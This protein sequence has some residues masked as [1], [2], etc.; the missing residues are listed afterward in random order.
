MC[1]KCH[2][3]NKLRPTLRVEATRPRHHQVVDP[4]PT[5]AQRLEPQPSPFQTPR[6]QVRHPYL[7]LDPLRG[8]RHRRHLGN[9]PAIRLALDPDPHLRPGP[10]PLSATPAPASPA[11]SAARTTG[12]PP[13]PAASAS[14]TAGSK[15]RR[16][17]APDRA[18]SGQPRH[19]APPSPPAGFRPTAR[20]W[21]AGPAP[22]LGSP[23]L[24]AAIDDPARQR[25]LRQPVPKR[26]Q[27]PE[28]RIQIVHRVRHG[29]LD[30]HVRRRHPHRRNPERRQVQHQSPPMFRPGSGASRQPRPRSSTAASPPRRF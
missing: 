19:P 27:S 4:D 14:R 20:R 18:R 7:A 2:R 21:E 12:W 9:R 30:R 22:R 24:E 16:E 6:R 26:D 3:Q 17:A 29:R 10:A 15:T 28:L 25:V 5:G 23:R 8:N 1:L 13:R 11:P